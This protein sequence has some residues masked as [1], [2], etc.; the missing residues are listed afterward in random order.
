MACGWLLMG[1]LLALLTQDGREGARVAVVVMARDGWAEVRLAYP[2]GTPAQSIYADVGEI[3][4]W[5]GWQLSAPTITWEAGSCVASCTVALS[6]QGLSIWPL[7]AAL[8]RYQE[9]V[10]AYLGPARPAAGQMENA[11]V[12]VRWNGS[13]TGT[14]YTVQ[15]KRRDFAG[16]SE[17]SAPQSAGAQPTAPLQR[18]RG[19]LTALVVALAIAAG[20]VTYL[21]TRPIFT[22]A[23]GGPG[24]QEET[25][26]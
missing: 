11:F 20:A 10:I 16:L 22:A 21:L 26:P 9:I 7:V 19:A 4:R 24:T 5:G 3:A 14:L 12:V 13:S 23:S 1:G 8:R 15:L 2:T 6:P 17:L 25:G 18:R